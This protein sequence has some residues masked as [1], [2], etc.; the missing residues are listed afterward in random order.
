MVLQVRVTTKE[1]WSERG[2]DDADQWSLQVLTTRAGPDGRGGFH[3][4]EW[5][6]V[7]L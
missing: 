7:L 6:A 3:M 1:Q 4:L 2:C 5:L